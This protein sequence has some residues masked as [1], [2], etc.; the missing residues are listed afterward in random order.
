MEDIF[1]TKSLMNSLLLQQA[2]YCKSNNIEMPENLKQHLEKASE[3]EKA[4]AEIN[5]IEAKY[6]IDKIC[7]K[8]K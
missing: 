4:E 2:I 6:L 8:E 1:D 3:E 7:E 5:L